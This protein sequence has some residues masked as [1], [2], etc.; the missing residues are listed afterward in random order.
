MGILPLEFP[1]CAQNKDPQSYSTTPSDTSFRNSFNPGTIPQ[2]PASINAYATGSSSQGINPLLGSSRDIFLQNAAF[3]LSSGRFR[4]RGLSSDRTALLFNGIRFNQNESGNASLSDLGG[5]AELSGNMEMKSGFCSSRTCFGDAGGLI[6]I[7]VQASAFQK[8]WKISY[9]HSNGIYTDRPSMTYASGLMKNGIAFAGSFTFRNAVKS[10]V[11]GTF[12]QGFTYMVVIDKKFGEHQ[13]LSLLGIGTEN[14]QGRKSMATD[15]VYRLTGNPFYNS[16]WGFQTDSVTHITRARSAKESTNK[17]NN[18]ILTHQYTPNENFRI[19]TSLSVSGS[20]MGLTGL[21][22]ENGFVTQPD[23]YKYLPSFYDAS[24]AKPSPYKYAY[25]SYNWIHDLGE[26][27]Q[28]NW[29][30]LYN[31]NYNDLHTIQNANGIAG[32]NVTGRLSKYIL[33]DQRKDLNAWSGSSILQYQKKGYFLSA[34]ISANYANTRHY[35]VIDNLLGGDFWLDIDQFVTPTAPDPM[36]AQNNIS[37][38]NA[39]LHKGDVFG[40]DYQIKTTH[41]EV[42]EQVEKTFGRFDTYLGGT[43]SESSF[44]RT[45]NMINGKF[46]LTSGGS[47]PASVF[48]NWGVKAGS[49][50]RISGRQYLA[51]NAAWLTK[52]PSA[53]NGYISPQTRGDRVEDEVPAFG[54]AQTRNADITWHLKYPL[55]RGRITLFRIVTTNDIWLRSYYDDVYKTLVNYILS[56]IN[57]L[58]QGVEGGFETN[59]TKRLTAIFAGSAASYIF[60]NRPTAT[61][62]ADNTAVLLATN[63]TTYLK[64]YHLG[65][66]PETAFTA[67]LRYTGKKNWVAAINYNHFADCYVIPN[68]DRRTADVLQKFLATD[69]EAKKI[70]K[71]EMLV[72]AYTLDAMVSKTFRFNRKLMLRAHITWNNLTNTIYK[73]AG[74]EQLRHDINDIDKF[75]NKYSYAMGMSWTT[76]LEV[77]FL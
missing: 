43:V 19:Q 69:P 67:G 66:A 37:K 39:P 47:G 44:E 17:R 11:P 45:G 8:G 59:L 32:N 41:L 2:S 10:Y 33:E 65:G 77:K 30:S 1:L 42:W 25:L 56:G 48:L 58:N 53:Q 38:P 62:S 50:F 12:A 3:H 15:E 76:G 73:N 5:I 68:P 9:N 57:E 31:A 75:P 51:V 22:E 60:T 74:M 24:A 13:S 70:V 21:N 72:A 35:K 16:F 18:L 55:V 14:D 49:I 64:N 27:R 26:L 4:A 29:N 71:Q 36:I 23:Y 52:A 46:P 54:S 20:K 28:V 61:I 6:S 7:S 34:G 63:R 40:Y